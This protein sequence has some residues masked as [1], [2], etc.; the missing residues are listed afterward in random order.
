MQLEVFQLIK[1]LETPELCFE[2]RLN[3]ARQLREALGAVQEHAPPEESQPR[4]MVGEA[5]ISLPS[6]HSHP[7][8]TLLS[9]FLLHCNAPS[10]IN[11]RP[12][13]LHKELDQIN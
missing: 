10:K 4:I 1:R 3:I 12:T 11:Q 13:F 7:K 5:D 9:E 8:G 6:F 2:E